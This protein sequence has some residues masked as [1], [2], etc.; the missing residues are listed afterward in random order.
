MENDAFNPEAE[1]AQEQQAQ[2]VEQQQQQSQVEGQADSSTASGENH[3]QNNGVQKRINE[4]TAKRYAAEREAK[5]LRERLAQAESAKPQA[6][7]ASDVT[8]PQLPEDLY[9]EDEMR[10]YHT[11]MVAYNQKIASQA[12]KS[13]YE[14]QQQQ[15]AQTKQQQKAQEM[16]NNFAQNAI[17]DGVSIDKLQAAETTL[18]QAGISPELGK[19]I[20]SDRNGGK[21]A[22]YL[23]DNPAIMHD[24]LSLDPVS[25]GIKIATEVKAAALST[26]PKVTGAP[27][28]VPTI[29]G[30]GVEPK[31][32]F[33]SK[34]PDT[35]FF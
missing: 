29:T 30:G 21:I 32:D 1:G 2:P 24:V 15:L 27:D 20:M 14:Q 3:E 6:P 28:P 22:E 18:N 12:G 5:E 23:H 8:P 4:L 25:A 34:Y 31:D 19:Y 13:A 10:K 16:I 7:I 11:E 9:D 26:T 35:E 33:E 17:S